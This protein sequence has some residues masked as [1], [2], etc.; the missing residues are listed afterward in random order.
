MPPSLLTV[1]S[2]GLDPSCNP[3]SS[4][5]LPSTRPSCLAIPVIIHPTSV[6]F[7]PLLPQIHQ[8]SGNPHCC[9]FSPFHSMLVFILS[10]LEAATRI[11]SSRL[12]CWLLRLLLLMPCPC[13]SQVRLSLIGS[14]VHPSH[15]NHFSED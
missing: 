9:P 14:I 15:K 2:S 6:I 5:H 7:C 12:H 4:S 1:T 3:H 13:L 8:T 11:I 10:I